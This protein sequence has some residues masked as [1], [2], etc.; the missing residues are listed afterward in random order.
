VSFFDR[1]HPRPDAGPADLDADKLA[2]EAVPAV[3]AASG[4]GW[5][6]DFANPVD[7]AVV[8]LCR[9]RRAQAGRHGQSAAGDA[10]V[11]RALEEADPEAVVWL[12]SRAV[13][14]MDEQGYPESL[15]PWLAS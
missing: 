7:R 12:A 2:Q 10:A 5:Y 1:K 6:D 14:Y 4:Q 13:S 9:L 15:A 3:N 8:T 11:R